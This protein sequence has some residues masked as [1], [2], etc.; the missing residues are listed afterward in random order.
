MTRRLLI[1]PS[2]THNVILIAVITC[3]SGSVELIVQQVFI[4]T[5]S[6]VITKCCQYGSPATD[7][8]LTIQLMCIFC[9]A[10]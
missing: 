5:L 10:Q 7:T 1:L 3:R 6:H 8:L 4:G 2:E 9:V